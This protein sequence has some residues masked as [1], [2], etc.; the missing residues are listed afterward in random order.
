MYTFLHLQLKHC[1]SVEGWFLLVP[2]KD[3][4]LSM[5]LH[6]AV[7]AKLFLEQCSDPHRQNPGT[8]DPDYYN[9]VRIGAGF[10]STA[11]KLAMEGDFVMNRDGG[12]SP[13]SGWRELERRESKSF[14]S[15]P[16]VG[17]ERIQIMKWADP[18]AT[19]FYLKSSKGRIF[20]PVKYDTLQQAVDAAKAFV[21]ES[22]ITIEKPIGFRR[23]D[24]D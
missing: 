14:I 20:S 11:M 15:F 17:G 8:R 4:N 16:D 5:D 24:G 19:H 21:P 7:A 2:A 3:F 23:R 6:R 12:L 10:L 13:L 22:S 1:P 9:V 18:D